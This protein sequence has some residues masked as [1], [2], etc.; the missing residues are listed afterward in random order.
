MTVANDKGRADSALLDEIR[1]VRRELAELR[2]ELKSAN[3]QAVEIYVDSEAIQKHFGISRA[4]VHN[5][6]H[7]EACPHEMRGKVLRF[8][9]SAVE[10]WF[11]GRKLRSVR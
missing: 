3:H 5:W 7:E 4:T 9:M 11:S 2:L 10:S 6:I 1:S 8:K